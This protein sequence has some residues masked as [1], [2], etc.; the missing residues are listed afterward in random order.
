MN[1]FKSQRLL[2]ILKSKSFKEGEFTLSSGA[3]SNVYIDCK[4]TTLD[5]EGAWLVGELCL[6]LILRESKKQNIQ[7]DGV[8]GLTMGADSISLATGM[9]SYRNKSSSHALNIF[10]V[11]KTPKKHGRNKL[12][13]GNFSI[14]DVV[15]VVDDVTTSGESTLQAA[16][17]IES[18][19]G[20]IAF[21][22]VLV[23]RQEGGKE[24]IES[25][26]YKVLSLF[27]KTDLLNDSSK[28]SKAKA[29]AHALTA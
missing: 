25:N 21:V 8:G 28:S 13:E 18:D 19:G 12:I 4:M 24:K 23:D 3:K 6:D 22:V 2:S 14:G 20:K 10:S 5:A 16:K 27:T 17:A 26:G 11:R 7:I 9:A 29:R 15:V 1:K